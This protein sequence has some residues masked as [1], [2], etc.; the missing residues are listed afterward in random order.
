MRPDDLESLVGQSLRQLPAPHAPRTLLPR[1]L[2]A[3][4]AWAARPWYSRAWF[5]WPLPLQ[6]A[7]AAALLVLVA[8]TAAGMAH[9]DS[10]SAAL[11]SAGA[12]RVAA[13]G[14]TVQTMAAAFDVVW[15]GIVLPVA[16][17]ALALVGMM[18]VACAA[19]AVAL[20]QVVMGGAVQ[21]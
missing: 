18:S 3:A 12:S 17:Y 20:N 14:V 13:A 10:A 1:V 7:S 19:G 16:P 5:T 6:I 4:S 21:R 8:A 9:V 2:A 11:L 15:R